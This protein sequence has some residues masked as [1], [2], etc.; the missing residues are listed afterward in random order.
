MFDTETEWIVG[1]TPR[2]DAYLTDAAGTAIDC[3]DLVL[4][5]MSPGGAVVTVS[6]PVRT[7]IG[8]YHHDLR[9]DKSGTWYYHWQGET[10]FPVVADGSL[11]V[12][13]SRFVA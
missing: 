8:T 11:V 5:I 4:K 13:P 1:Q 10:P 7:A 12:Q 3:T 6:N 2:L 9:V